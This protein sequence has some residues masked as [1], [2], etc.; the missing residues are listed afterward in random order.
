[1]SVRA[2]LFLNVYG[3]KPINKSI[4]LCNIFDGALCPLPMYNFT[5]S[6][7]LTLPASLGVSDRIPNIAFKIPDLEAYAQL[8][9]IEVGT[10]TVKACVQA[11]L[12]N[13]W[14]ARQTGVEWSTRA[15]ALLALLLAIPQPFVPNA[16]APFR[17]LDL[18]F[19]YQSISASAFLQLNYPSVYRSFALNFAWSMGL[20]FTSATSSVQNAINV[21]RHRT[22]GTM[23]NAS[24]SAIGLVN[25]KLSPYNDALI[26]PLRSLFA[27]WQNGTAGLAF[28]A[29]VR[30]VVTVTQ[31]SP[32]VLQAGIPIY[33]NSVNVGTAN[34]FMTV[35][36]CSLILVAILLSLLGL[37]YAVLVALCRRGGDTEERY[38]EWKRAYPNFARAWALRMVRA[39]R[40]ICNPVF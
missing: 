22:G 2:N 7:Y 17:F 24:G 3:M 39:R 8:S 23:P 1:M 37:G 18:L 5:G 11:T 33:V 36:I 9:L 13:G 25:R 16:L 4:D 40:N 12:S 32:N 27:S 15:M 38:G 29:P 19:L 34:A 20:V 10:G 14:S 28:E 30:E 26:N 21:M 35:F 6:D 31:S